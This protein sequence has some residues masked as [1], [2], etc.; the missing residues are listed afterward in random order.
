MTLGVEGR[1]AAARPSWLRVIEAEYGCRQPATV[2]SKDIST[3]LEI[4]RVGS[5][6]LLRVAL[7]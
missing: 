4:T 6:V 7:N 5:F 1:L 3:R 2:T